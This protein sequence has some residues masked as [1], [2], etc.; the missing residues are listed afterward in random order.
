MRVETTSGF[1]TKSHF[2]NALQKGLQLPCPGSSS[3]A[4]VM[5]STGRSQSV[6]GSTERFRIL[7]RNWRDLNDSVVTKKSADCRWTSWNGIVVHITDW[8]FRNADKSNSR[9]QAVAINVRNMNYGY[10][11]I[12][13]HS[14][15]KM[16][17][18]ISNRDFIYIYLHM[19]VHIYI[20]IYIYLQ[21]AITI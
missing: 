2:T 10:M 13:I 1:D 17:V 19:H 21:E 11:Y 8:S 3:E 7:R 5:T 4:W 15:S 6:P 12:Y 14:Q 16:T 9:S 20:Y 18:S